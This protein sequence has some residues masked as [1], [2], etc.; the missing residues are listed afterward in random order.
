VKGSVELLA[1][2]VVEVLGV[3]VLAGEVLDVG[4]AVSFEGPVP[5]EGLADVCEP[6]VVVGGG[7][8]CW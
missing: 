1:C 7:G 4:V 8:V 3:A 2:G 6:V 5:L